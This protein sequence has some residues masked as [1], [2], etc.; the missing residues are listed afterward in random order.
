[1]LSKA[2]ASNTSWNISLSLAQLLNSAIDLETAKRSRCRFCPDGQSKARSLPELI[3]DNNCKLCYLRGLWISLAC[4]LRQITHWLPQLF[5]PA[6]AP[7]SGFSA[8]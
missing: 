7:P 5:G 3:L 4:V 1:M 6:H 2:S 8:H